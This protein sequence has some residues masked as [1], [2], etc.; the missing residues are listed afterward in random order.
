[1]S[2]S[3]SPEN[4][5]GRGSK[6]APEA[7]VSGIY[8]KGTKESPRIEI[9]DGFFREG[10]GL[11]GDANSGEGPRQVCLLR[12]EDRRDVE[13]D[14]REGLCFPR[15]RETVQTEGLA[16]DFLEKGSRLQAGDAVLRVSRK[17]KKCWPECRIIQAGSTCALAGSVRFLEVVVT[18]RIRK[19]DAIIPLGE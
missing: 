19:N 7:R 12:K 18:G 14:R 4:P 9:P 1:M 17:G 3:S 2:D 16:L 5:P 11:E 6:A 8:L 10:Y 15:F 13:A